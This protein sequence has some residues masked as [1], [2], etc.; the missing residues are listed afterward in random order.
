MFCL[1]KYYIYFFFKSPFEL[2]GTGI[3]LSVGK[4]KA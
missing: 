4:M 1:I 3:G 2:I